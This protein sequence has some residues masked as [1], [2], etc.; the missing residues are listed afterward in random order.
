M[1]NEIEPPPAENRRRGKLC[2][3]DARGWDRIQICVERPRYITDIS[4][5]PSACHRHRGARFRALRLHLILPG[6]K[7]GLGLSDAQAGGPGHGEHDRVL[8]RAPLALRLPLRALQ[9][10]EDNHR[11]HAAGLGFMLVTGLAPDFETASSA[12]CSPAWAAGHEHPLMGLVVG[13]FAMSR[14]GQAAGGT[15]SGSSF[16]RSSRGL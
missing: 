1:M 12:A 15:V 11:F 2:W 9:P 7:A 14:R 6:M 13:W 10:Q 5:L 8:S 16:G 4:S 3:N